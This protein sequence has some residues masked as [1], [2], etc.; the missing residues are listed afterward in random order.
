MVVTGV[1]GVMPL[2][3]VR[4]QKRCVV[5]HN[6]CSIR[7]SH[8]DCSGRTHVDVRAH[9]AR[10]VQ[11]GVQRIGPACAAADLQDATRDRR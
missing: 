11:D 3:G 1:V 2:T 7:L 9:Q 5:P 10:Q 4:Q 8:T 6:I